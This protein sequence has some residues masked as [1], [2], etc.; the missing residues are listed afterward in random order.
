[1]ADRT[2]L[3][4]EATAPQVKGQAV[5]ESPVE[6]LLPY[7]GQSSSLEALGELD[8]VGLAAHVPAVGWTLRSD[9]GAA[10]HHGHLGGRAEHPA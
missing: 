5:R 8:A 1:M 10:V 4:D 6:L 9:S 7:L 2:F 3:R